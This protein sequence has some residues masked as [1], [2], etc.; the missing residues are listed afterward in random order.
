MMILLIILSF[1][2]G[3]ILGSFL[4][5]VSL[6][7]QTGKS[8]QGRSYCFSCGTT[9][10]WYELIP[11]VSYL[12]QRGRCRTCS[13]RIPRETFVTELSLG[14]VFAG[15]ATRGLFLG[16]ESLVWTMPYLFGTLFLFV[17]FSV[18]ALVFLYDMRHKIIPDRLSL[19]FAV[20]GLVG[21]FFFDTSQGVFTFVGPHLP[22]IWNMVGGVLVPLPF[23]LIWKFS[24]GRM[25]GLG[26]PKLMVGI[27]FL[28]GTFGGFSAV[29][30]SFWVGTLFILSA[31]ITEKILGHKLFIRGRK[32]IMKQEIP[33]GPFLIIG[34]LLTIVFNIQLLPLS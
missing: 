13:S 19:I 2:L 30:V 25:M 5:V 16:A 10:N 15:I 31:L 22:D 34:L 11:L 28:L 14:V 8:L 4:L 29:F 27:G 7:Y 1:L 6:R 12:A 23:F 3:T 26:D 18:L 32:G 20:L 21:M 24:R 9:L 33:F 17:V